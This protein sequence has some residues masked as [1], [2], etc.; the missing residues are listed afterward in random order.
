VGFSLGAVVGTLA[1]QVDTRFRAA[2]L[3]VGA[4]RLA[5]IVAT[6]GM[7]VK[8]QRHLRSRG[9]TRDDLERELRAVDAVSYVGVNP[10]CRIYMVNALHDWAIP[11]EAVRETHAAFGQPLVQWL[12]AG[13]FTTFALPGPLSREII[14]FLR[15]ALAPTPGEFS[16]QGLYAVN[17]KVGFLNAA[18][19]GG[20]AAVL[21]EAYTISAGSRLVVDLGALND[22]L[23][24]GISARAAEN[25]SVGVGTPVL[26]SEWDPQFYW[27]LHVTY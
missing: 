3:V 7:L 8:L 2:A 17:L 6:S 15:S 9:I 22:N 27:M 23:W 19:Q 14:R 10:D 25:L 13:H 5:R 24:A 1:S 16:P 12:N 20:K 18:H 11:E 4:A 26:T 21:A